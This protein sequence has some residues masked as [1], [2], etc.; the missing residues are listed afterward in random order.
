MTGGHGGRDDGGDDGGG[1]AS[2]LMDRLIEDE[3]VASA[4]VEDIDDAELLAPDGVAEHFTRHDP[5]RVLRE[6]AAKRAL[7]HIWLQTLAGQ[8]REHDPGALAVAEQALAH[9]ASVYADHPDYRP[10]W[11]PVTEE[12]CDRRDG[13]ERTGN[14]VELHRGRRPRRPAG[15]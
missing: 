3:V 7:V 9:L 8:L 6:V 2:F 15:R 10:G 4:A 13:G 1:L 11:A 12:R 14:V 5:V